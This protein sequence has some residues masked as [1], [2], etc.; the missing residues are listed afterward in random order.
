MV[1]SLA[2][3]DPMA[4]LAARARALREAEGISQREL[5]RRIFLSHT[6][7]NNVECARWPVSWRA[8]E[9]FVRG[10]APE[11]DCAVWEQM[12]R[13]ADRAY[14][15]RLSAA[16][17]ATPA[18]PPR[19]V[20][21]VR[22]RPV[23]RKVVLR[24]P[25]A[26]RRKFYAPLP[27]EVASV[28]T[29]VAALGR[30]RASAGNPSF[31]QIAA[32]SA[33]K[34]ALQIGVSAY[35]DPVGR[36]T[37]HDLFKP[38]RVDLHW[39]AVCAFLIGCGLDAEEI[40]YWQLLLFSRLPYRSRREPLRLTRPHD[41]PPEVELAGVD[42]ASAFVDALRRLA[43]AS[44]RAAEQIVDRARCHAGTR[45]YGRSAVFG[46]FRR[47]NTVGVLPERAIVEG[48]LRGCY[49]ASEGTFH[50]GRLFVDCVPDCSA[51]RIAPWLRLYDRLTDRD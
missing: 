48:F 16:A 43:K 21:K 7:V 37:L 36:S 23:R 15:A 6:V 39:G 19:A 29:Y 50:G 40:E 5:G 17:A 46:R 9:A 11:A 51:D 2:G 4:A 18:S 30:L 35:A 1:V 26:Y 8:V 38:G 41:P 45:I 25:E 28:D 34:S 14:R 33:A 22:K 24:P 44:G 32:R 3:A 49:C 20:G 12:W 42:S 13:E 31:R 27:R 10:C 47:A